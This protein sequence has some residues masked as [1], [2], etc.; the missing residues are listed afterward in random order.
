MAAV[1]V[2]TPAAPGPNARRSEPPLQRQWPNADPLVLGN[3]SARWLL[4]TPWNRP[5]A[6]LDDREPR[7]LRQA[8]GRDPAPV[9]VNN[10]LDPYR[11]I[12]PAQA[13]GRPRAAAEQ[14]SR[15]AH[16]RHALPPAGQDIDRC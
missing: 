14:R 1:F 12:A 15:L 10:L 4:L 13:L 5:R 6:K 7:L 16:A 9:A 3:R 11:A 8:P 2:P